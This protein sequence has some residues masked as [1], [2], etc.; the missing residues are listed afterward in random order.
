M[1][2]YDIKHPLVIIPFDKT[3]IIGIG[4]RIYNILE[5]L[6]LSPIRW[7]ADNIPKLLLQLPFTLE[8]TQE[9]IQLYLR[10]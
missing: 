9:D 7:W 3:I 4:T 8:L 1:L 6:L 10:S 2:F 5:Q